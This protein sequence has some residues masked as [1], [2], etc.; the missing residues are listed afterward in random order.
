M[1]AN[2]IVRTVHLSLGGGGDGSDFADFFNLTAANV[3]VN[4]VLSQDTST[5]ALQGSVA[6]NG[7]TTN[8]YSIEQIQGTGPTFD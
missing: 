6:I 4:V 1:N 5:G 3:G 2:R 8:L 7:G